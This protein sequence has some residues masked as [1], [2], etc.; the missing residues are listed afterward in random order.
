MLSTLISLPVS[1]SFGAISLAG[2]SVSGVS[3][4]LTKKYQK[5]LSKVRKLVDIVTSA[6][7]VFER[8]VS[9]ALNNGKID[10]KE[11]NTLQMFHLKVLNEL[12]N[13][14]CKMGTENRIQFEKSI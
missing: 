1:I 7:A 9:K 3:T 13:I 8:V 12:S 2:V 5:K 6:L 4:A 10:K 14:D 11:F